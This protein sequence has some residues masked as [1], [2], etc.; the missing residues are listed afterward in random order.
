MKKRYIFLTFITSILI[1]GIFI[2]SNMNIFNTHDIGDREAG[3]VFSGLVGIYFIFWTIVLG[4]YKE[5]NPKSYKNF[6]GD[7]I[8]PFYFNLFILSFLPAIFT[9]KIVYRY[10]FGF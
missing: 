7:G 6:L 10:V 8:G 9:A 1:M 4:V 3:F 2:S 5:L